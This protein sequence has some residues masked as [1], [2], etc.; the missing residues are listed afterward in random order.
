MPGCRHRL[1]LNVFTW[2]RV[3]WVFVF[4]FHLK[5]QKDQLTGS[6]EIAFRRS[7]VVFVENSF[8][9]PLSHSFM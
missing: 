1:R 9:H 8:I 4:F 6:K 7:T 5:S 2:G 3:L